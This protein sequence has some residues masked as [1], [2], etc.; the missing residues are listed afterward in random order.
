M[1]VLASAILFLVTSLC[2]A[3]E[4]VPYLMGSLYGYADLDGNL[5]VSADFDEAM[6]FESGIAAVQKGL[7]WGAIDSKGQIIVPFEYEFVEMGFMNETPMLFVGR[8]SLLGLFNTSGNKL[9]ECEYEQVAFF[10]ENIVGCV[11]GQCTIFGKEG[12]ELVELV[13]EKVIFQEEQEILYTLNEKKVGFLDPQGEEFFATKKYSSIEPLGKSY[14]VV[15][16][17][18]KKTIVSNQNTILDKEGAFEDASLLDQWV[19]VK[20]KGKWGL[21]NDAGSYTLLPD[22]E[23]IKVINEHL[24]AAKKAGKFGLFDY[25]G[26]SKSGFLYKRVDKIRGTDQY[27]KAYTNVNWNLLT[28]TGDATGINDVFALNIKAIERDG[29]PFKRDKWGVMNKNGEIII[30][31]IYTM[32]YTTKSGNFIVKKANKYGVVSA[33]GTTLIEEKYDALQE[34]DDYFLAQDKDKY[35]ILDLQGNVSGETLNR[36]SKQAFMPYN[37]FAVTDGE[38]QGV[39]NANGDIIVPIKFNRLDTIHGMIVGIQGKDKY[40]YYKNGRQIFEDPYIDFEMTTL[41]LKVKLEEDNITYMGLYNLKDDRWFLEPK[42]KRIIPFNDDRFFT[43]QSRIDFYGIAD[44]NYQILVEPIYEKLFPLSKNS[45]LYLK[46]TDQGYYLM[47]IDEELVY[48]EPF[49]LVS[50]WRGAELGDFIFLVSRNDMYGLMNTEGKML[51]DVEYQEIAENKHLDESYFRIGKNGK[52]GMIDHKGNIVIQPVYKDIEELDSGWFW[53][54]ES[55]DS[56]KYLINHEGKAFS[57]H[58]NRN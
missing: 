2:C 14:V 31:P 41:G 22:Y 32:I 9:L 39:L 51:L 28:S 34:K 49:E 11:P 12:N 42:W 7:N 8:N 17:D 48:E 55:R 4:L 1:R 56:K 54:L 37:L 10:G 53:V 44:T 30:E 47:R 25:Q 58:L 52:Q 18:E 29:I 50:I 5:V 15:S 3:Q 46:Q 45:A 26:N 21:L 16:K 27:I 6:P 36:W 57:D 33:N 43:L 38:L 40:I 19:M 13:D 23:E 20:K 24:I 35:I